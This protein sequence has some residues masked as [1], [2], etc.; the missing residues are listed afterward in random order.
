M[1]GCRPGFASEI[2][3]SLEE[4]AV[5]TVDLDPVLPPDH[6]DVADGHVVGADDDAA[7]DDRPWLAVEDLAA[8]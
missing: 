5:G 2:D 7:L 4:N 6:G 1:H 3:T 8:S